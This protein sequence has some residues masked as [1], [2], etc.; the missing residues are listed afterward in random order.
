MKLIPLIIKDQFF[1]RVDMIYRMEKP[2]GKV[3][4]KACEGIDALFASD[5][6]IVDYLTL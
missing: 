1:I 3:F 6:F 5:S 4:Q 2:P